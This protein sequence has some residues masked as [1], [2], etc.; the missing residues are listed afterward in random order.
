M[1]WWQLQYRCQKQGEK[2]LPP[3]ADSQQ[4]SITIL[5]ELE[6]Y[7][8]GKAREHDGQMLVEVRGL[9]VKVSC[10]YCYNTKSYRNGPCKP[11]KVLHNWISGKK[12]YLA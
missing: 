5:L 9:T 1:G 4:D 2:F 8:V 3:M 11:R 6:G 10:P 7:Q 12:A